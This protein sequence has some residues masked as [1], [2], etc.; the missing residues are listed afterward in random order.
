M[1]KSSLI[2]S[3]ALIGMFITTPALAGKKDD[4]DDRKARYM[5]HYQQ[6]HQMN[7]D[8]M[9]ML[10]ETMTILQGLNHMP[11]AKQQE[12]LG[13]MIEQLDDMMKMH[14][15]M[16]SMMMKNKDKMRGKMMMDENDDSDDDDR[17]MGKQHGKH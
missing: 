17:G 15:E 2:L 6:R 16:G 8:M 3:S 12:Q 9:H 1:K 11:S 4:N 7:M 10:S 13:E 5:E 14:E